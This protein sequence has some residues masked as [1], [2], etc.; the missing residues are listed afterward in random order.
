MKPQPSSHARESAEFSTAESCARELDAKDPLATYRGQFHIP[1]RTDGK[2]VIYFAGH[3]L[4]LMPKCVRDALDQELS[5]W[6][7]LGVGGH[8][9]ANT[10]WYKYHETLRGPAARL[11]GAEPDEVVIMNSLTVNLH[12]MM[13]TFYRP[14]KDRSKILMEDAAFP[15]DTYAIKTQ[16]RHH[17]LDPGN[18]LV[19]AKP[20]N[21]EH[22]IRT[23]DIE[24]ILEKQGDEIALVLLGGVQYFTGQVFDMARIT[25]A[26]R[27]H[28]CVVGLDLAHA[29][30]N[31]ELRLHDW[32]VDFAVWCNYKYLNSGPGAVGGC[33]VHQRHATNVDLHRLGGW[34]GN[35]PATRF[36]MHLQPEFVPVASAT[37][38]QISNPPVLSLAAVKASYELFDEVG[39]SAIREKSKRL[40]GYLSFLIDDLAPDRVEVVTPRESE[41]RGCQLS[42]LVHERPQELLDALKREGVVGDFREPNVV[43]IAPV[44]LYNSFLDV[45][46]FSR[47]LARHVER[48]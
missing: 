47:I 5:D 12:L 10:P 38:W 21:G 3:S 16:L 31:V 17:G 39:L 45:W 48:E 46:S 25:A 29:A 26:A 28:G 9:E 8:F 37:G 33:F 22:T 14:T 42:M 11:V 7:R 43:R 23:D 18:A 19:I 27:K 30:G 15:S 36:R 24:A 40:T 35:D 4:G 13:M 34:W 44:P 2:D 1:K 20:R 41:A 32:D 6:A